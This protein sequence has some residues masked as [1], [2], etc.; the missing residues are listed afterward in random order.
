MGP[1]APQRAAGAS[2]RPGTPSGD[3][4]CQR[5]VTEAVARLAR[6]LR[7]GETE[8]T[9]TDAPCQPRLAAEGA[10]GMPG[11]D[12]NKPRATSIP[13]IAAGKWTDARIRVAWHTCERQE[14]FSS[15]APRPLHPRFQLGAR[16]S[17]PTRPSR[18]PAHPLNAAQPS[19]AA[20]TSR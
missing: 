1:T 6:K 18:C 10:P 8:A 9:Q 19:I 13:V 2:W 3:R 4:S 15:R 20:A 7:A 5:Q 14:P 12:S 17:C 16:R 11:I